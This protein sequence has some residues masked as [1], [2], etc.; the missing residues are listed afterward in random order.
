MYLLYCME[1]SPAEH[2]SH[3]LRLVSFEN[4]EGPHREILD[5]IKRCMYST[6]HT[7]L[8]NAMA[9]IWLRRTYANLATAYIH[10][11]AST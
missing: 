3:A 6:V 7:Q 9:P 10:T 8:S 1:E 5:R 11:V 2:V 4:M